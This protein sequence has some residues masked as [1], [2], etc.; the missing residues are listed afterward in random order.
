MKARWN[1]QIN[2]SRRQ[3]FSLI[4]LPILI[5]SIIINLLFVP[6]SFTEPL[7]FGSFVASGKFASQGKNPYSADSPLIFRIEFPKINHSSLAPNL[8]PPI[9]VMG[10]E[11]I[12]QMPIQFSALL[13]RTISVATYLFLSLLIFRN[14]GGDTQRFPNNR[15]RFIWMLTLAGFWHCV[16]LG[17][18][19]I[20]ML[21]FAIMAWKYLNSGREI[22]GGLMLGLLIAIKPNFVLWAVTLLISTNWRPFV[23]AGIVSLGIS[24]FPILMYGPEIYYQWLE[25]SSRFVPDLLIFPGNSSFQ[26]LMARFN[27]PEMGI[28]FS[29]LLS[30]GMLVFVF[31]N[32]P[33]L[34]NIHSIGI[35]TSLLI[36]PIAWT[37]YTLLTIPIFLEKKEWDVPYW[38]SALIFSTPFFIILALFQNSFFNFIFWGWFYGWGL[39]ILLARQIFPPKS[40]YILN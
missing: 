36:S 12:S 29:V 16:Q 4:S 5:I 17:Q 39:V 24:A 3:L 20:I 8:N 22:L 18:I 35:I 13:W 14:M 31:F 2:I 26:G 21:L 11:A 7:D 25:A 40:K 27:R 15:W 38:I 34:P 1:M 10:F 30:A 9:S 37:G 33:K 32:K 28:T 23:V 6:T 19:Y